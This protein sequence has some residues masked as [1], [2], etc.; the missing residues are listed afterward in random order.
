MT[1]FSAPDYPQFVPGGLPRYG[2]RAAV[3]RLSAPDY[4]TPQMIQFDAA[5]PRPQVSCIGW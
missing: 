1:V 5:L 2:N 3:A 4:A